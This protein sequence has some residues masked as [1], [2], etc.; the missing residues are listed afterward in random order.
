[1]QIQLKP[2]L[3]RVWRAP[4]IVQIGLSDRR[5]TLLEGL[6]PED[7]RVLDELRDGLDPSE[8]EG[9]AR[10]LVDMLVDAGVVTLRSE[11]P[12]ADGEGS[13][14]WGPDAAVWSLVHPGGG[15]G[16]DVLAGRRA[17]H[18]VVHGAGRLGT[19]LAATLAAAGV[20]F[21]TVADERHTMATDLAP[22]GANDRDLGRPRAEVAVDVVRRSGGR[23]GPPETRPGGWPDAVVLVDHGAANAARADPFLS[24][25]VPH[26]SVVV[27]EDDVVV[28]PLVRPGRGPCLRCLDRHRA[29]RDPAWPSV[30]AQVL[31]P[32]PGTPEPE[33]TGSVTVAAGLAALQVLNQ[34]DGVHTP[35]S[36]GATLEVELP[37]GLTARRVWP[38]HPGCG[39]HWPL[40]PE[41]ANDERPPQHDGQPAGARE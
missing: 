18:V 3:R 28:G 40:S 39:C 22:A 26:L 41:R 31:A 17:S 6:T 1:M 34:L 11:A 13:G 21:V 5:G 7:A 37:G 8:T 4:G 23:T 12:P 25:D 33:E 27:R 24:A 14:R 38:A 10:Q 32:A 36:A 16:W 19:T 15:D 30:L 29:D 2:A 20:G 9:R 35:P